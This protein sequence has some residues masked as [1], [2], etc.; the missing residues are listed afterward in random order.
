MVPALGPVEFGRPATAAGPREIDPSSI[1][2]LGRLP[3]AVLLKRVFLVDVLECP[4]CKG[5]M[6]IL[7]AVTEP[8][9]AAF[10][11]ISACPARRRACRLHVHALRRCRSWSWPTGRHI[12]TASTLTHRAQFSSR[13]RGMEGKG[14]GLPEVGAAAG[15]RACFPS[16]KGRLRGAS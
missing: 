3:W 4:K 14:R 15:N 11:I 16:G 10:S 2:R 13:G 12:R 8:A 6:K 7:A 9:R 1:P 5:R